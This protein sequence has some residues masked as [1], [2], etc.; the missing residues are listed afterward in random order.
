[1]SYS[2]ILWGNSTT[3]SVCLCADCMK[4]EVVVAMSEKW[5]LCWGHQRE[6]GIN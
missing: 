6:G 3:G 2:L 4:S 1:M 5:P